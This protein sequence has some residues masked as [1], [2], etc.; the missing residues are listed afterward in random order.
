MKA[1]PM[2]ALRRTRRFTHSAL[3]FALLCALGACASITTP[4]DADGIDCFN[5]PCL[6]RSDDLSRLLHY[7]EQIGRMSEPARRREYELA[8]REFAREPNSFNRVRLALF[9]TV[10]DTPFQCD[11]CARD[12]LREYLQPGSNDRAWRDF[13]ALLLRG[14]EERVALQQALD[15]ERQQHQQAREQLEK[16]KAIE[17]RINDRDRPVTTEKQAP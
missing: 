8:E 2:P 7:A 9:L 10:P 4:R 14:A 15:S 17:K 3:P 6:T 1:R 13:A 16:L 5:D 11:S 12:L